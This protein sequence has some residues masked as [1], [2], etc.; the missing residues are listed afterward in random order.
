[1]KYFSILILIS[2]GISTGCGRKENDRKIAPGS[3][4]QAPP[5]DALFERV[6][7]AASGLDFQ[8]TLTETHQENILNNSYLYN[9]GGV[10]VGDFN[11]DGKPDL[12]FVSTQGECKLFQNEGNFKFRDI[13]KEAGVT[14]PEGAKTGVTVAD[15][16]ADG[17]PDIYVCRTGM[18]PGENR[19]NLLFINNHNGTFSEKGREFGLADLSASNHANFFDMD[20]DGDLDCYLVNYPT[21]FKTVNNARVKEENGQLTRLT[22]PVTPY[23]SDRLYRNNGDNTFTDVTK[24]AGIEN[25]AYGLSATVSDFN[26]DGLLDIFVANDYI[27]PDFVYLNDPA[28]PGHFTDRASEFFRHTSNHTMGADI[29]DI[30]ADG[31]P[32]IVGLDMLAKPYDRQKELMTTMIL[33]R[34]NT[35]SKIGYG[36]QQ[37][38]NVLQLNNGN[39]TYSEIGCLAGIYQT[40]WS[41]TPLLQDFDNDG[42]TDLF[43]S[44]GYRR[45]VSNLDY[46]LF[47]ADS[48]QRSGGLT[49]KRFPDIEDYLEM[50]PSTPLQN[51]CFR[52]R[53]NLTFEDVS[54]AWGLV[55]QTYSSGA[56]TAD[57]DNDGD[58]DLIVSNLDSPALLYRNRS[59]EKGASWLQVSLEGNGKN[60]QAFGARVRV[61]IGEKV[62]YQ[63][64]TPVRGFLSSVEPLLHFGLGQARQIDRLEVE[65]PGNQVITLQNLAPNQRYTLKQADAKPGKLSP[66]PKAAAAFREVP[67]PAFTHTDDDIQDFNRERLLP[68][69]LS[70][71][72]PCLAVG[73]VNGDGLDDFFAG[74]GPGQPGGLFIQKGG[75]F[76][77]G[78]TAAWAADQAS[79]DTGALFFDADDDG[80]PDLFV[81]SG[82][83]SFP[84]NDARYQPRLY[85]NDGR[86]NFTKADKAL[87]KLTVSASVASAHDFDKDGDL[88]LFIGG[89]CTP[90]AY[91]TTPN[92]YILR[93]EKGIFTEIT[94]QAA[95]E[96]RQIG[97]VRAL[98]WAD[99]DG[100]NQA[101]LIVTGEWMPIHIFKNSSGSLQ[102]VT[103][104]YGLDQSQGFWR[105]V[106]VADLDGDGDK[107]LVAGNLGLNTRYE[108]TPE[109]PLR[110]YARDFD[111]NGS[112]DPLMS[113]MYAG[114]EV[115]TALRDV[116]LKQLPG[117]KKK[118]VHY[119]EYSRATITD[120]FPE[121]DLQSAQVLRANYLASAIWINDGGRFRPQNLPIEAQF[122]P[123]YGIVVFDW[124]ADGDPDLLLAGNDYGQQVETG[125]CDAGNG[126]LL[127]NTGKGNYRAVAPR[128]SGFW[129]TREAR[130]LKIVQAAG[131][132]K[133]VVVANNNGPL[134]LFQLLNN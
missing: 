1:M 81:A 21:D 106:A 77:A 74:N 125:R 7:P 113:Q 131:G 9:G 126:L 37:M 42:Y 20:N 93:N 61:Q 104:R 8:N 6:E 97:M 105:C 28:R 15:V 35:L 82:G 91:P 23:D 17:W 56:V 4:V 52:N 49:Q 41:W 80:D 36:H 132:R 134:Q 29:A 22:G 5:A 46:L 18:Q 53:G 115:P 73:D 47:T 87:P 38:R 55:E 89:G 119:K 75:G 83:N 122:A 118:F 99:L 25:R 109:L 111:G 60:T 66:L 32:D 48:I 43:V 117:L 84:A 116:M 90:L 54:T 101:E 121:K 59:A 30:N 95:P 71:P 72:G 65:F 79:E 31:L 13:A 85:L 102:D 68:W 78:S 34:Y 88:D 127:E 40:D 62:L 98:T 26:N 27:E 24:E 44:N 86:G 14:A 11:R 45:D 114:R 69:R 50:I 103:A 107:D 2:I 3:P 100:D 16:D 123:V 96:F 94:G 57:L 64:L 63:E 76:Q 128:V 39:G 10:G 124:Q 67:A 92:S 33:D 108:A 58:L 129:A 51:F 133:L 19:R 130:D 12:Y 110:L 120:L 70:T 112:I